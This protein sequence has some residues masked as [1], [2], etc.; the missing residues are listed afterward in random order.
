[1]ASLQNLR[2]PFSAQ[3]T[4]LRSDF[5]AL[6]EALNMGVYAAGQLETSSYVLS[7]VCLSSGP[8]QTYDRRPRAFPKP[9]YKQVPQEPPPLRLPVCRPLSENLQAR[10]CQTPARRCTEAPPVETRHMTE[11]PSGPRAPPAPPP[12]PA[13]CLR[14]LARGRHGFSP[15]RPFCPSGCPRD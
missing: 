2:K 14:P 7:L 1:M 13:G 6:I 8:I 11:L 10:L 12:A 4:N 9:F 15:S 3:L 5:E